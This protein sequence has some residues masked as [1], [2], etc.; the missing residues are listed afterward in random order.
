MNKTNIA[1]LPPTQ[2][3]WELLFA[4]I[5]HFL[6]QGIEKIVLIMRGSRVGG[7]GPP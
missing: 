1:H 5:L 3:F 2:G 7:G 6:I 4:E